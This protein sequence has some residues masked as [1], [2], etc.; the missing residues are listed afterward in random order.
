MWHTM[1]GSRSSLSINT[2]RLGALLQPNLISRATEWRD[3]HESVFSVN[4]CSS[5]FVGKGSLGPLGP[6]PLPAARPHLSPPIRSHPHFRSLLQLTL[7]QP[8][9]RDSLKGPLNHRRVAQPLRSQLFAACTHQSS[10]QTGV[11]GTLFHASAASLMCPEG[12][13]FREHVVVAMSSPN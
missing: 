13:R 2:T 11:S 10:T 9:G 6:R 4:E 5:F 12:S 8:L 1:R 7:L 3:L